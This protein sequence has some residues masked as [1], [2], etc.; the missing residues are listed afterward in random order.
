MNKIVEILMKRDNM[1]KEE[2]IAFANDVRDEILAADPFEAEEIMIE[3]LNLELDFLMD[4][5]E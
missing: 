2:A 5:F 3:E 1:T 4:L